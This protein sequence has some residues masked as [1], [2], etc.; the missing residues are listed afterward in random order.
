MSRII[1]EDGTP[2]IEVPSTPHASY[3]FGGLGS[4][5]SFTVR[6]LTGGKHPLRTKTGWRA[7]GLIALVIAIVVGLIAV[8]VMALI[9]V[10]PAVAV[11]G[12]GFWVRSKLVGRKFGGPGRGHGSVV[13]TS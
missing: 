5:R 8:S 1:N 10:V 11:I 9:V 7:V 12:L 6:D 4:A 13:T 3:P 2:V